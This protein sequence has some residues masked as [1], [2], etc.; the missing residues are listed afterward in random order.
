MTAQIVPIRAVTLGRAAREF[1]AR[2][3]LDG[4]IVRSCGQTMR[5]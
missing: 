1:P 2:R 3:D 4:D 5:R